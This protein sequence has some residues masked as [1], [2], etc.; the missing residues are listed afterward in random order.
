MGVERIDKADQAAGVQRCPRCATLRPAQTDAPAW[1][2]PACGIAYAKHASHLK[3]L[4][5]L[6][7]PRDPGSRVLRDW[8]G[9]RSLWALV[10]ANLLALIL[11]F[12][13]HWSLGSLMQLYWAQSVIIGLGQV[14]R[15][16]SL[17]A[18][19]T[20]GMT[21]NDRPVAPT[22]GS[23][24]QIALFFLVHY[25]IFHAVYLAFLVMDIGAPPFDAFFFTA[26]AGF[27]IHH[28]F[29]LRYNI[30]VDRRGKPNV[31]TLMFTPYLRILPMHL[32]ILFGG[33][34]DGGAGA[35][36]LFGLLKLGADVGMHLVEHAIY[37]GREAAGTS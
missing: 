23:K 4:A 5:A 14:L 21:M 26:I 34:F 17:R 6:E 16:L 8:H 12:S 7:Q 19:S 25:G 33:L 32:T 10:A 22:E 1:Q 31:G 3:R 36:L 27:L 13:E 35:L 9:D 2:C 11:A 37:Q 20:D 30:E 29:S 15:I 24:R 28:L 18:F